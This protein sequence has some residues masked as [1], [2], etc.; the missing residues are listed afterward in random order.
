MEKNFKDAIAGV[1]VACFIV[2]GVACLSALCG[3]KTDSINLVF[4]DSTNT[5]LVDM[6]LNESTTIPFVSYR[7]GPYAFFRAGENASAFVWASGKATITNETS[8]LGI[9]TS[10]E[11]KC[12]D[13]SLAVS[14]PNTTNMTFKAKEE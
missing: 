1:A 8:A 5:E 3:C 7:S 12:L 11:V 6:K 9:Y 13:L 4:S 2:I 10:H 14:L